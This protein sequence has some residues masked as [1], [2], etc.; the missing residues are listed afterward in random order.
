[1]NIV[2]ARCMLHVWLDPFRDTSGMLLS[3]PIG[4]VAMS[5]TKWSHLPKVTTAV[6]DTSR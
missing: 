4:L 1:M 5:W 3:S 2:S 6:M